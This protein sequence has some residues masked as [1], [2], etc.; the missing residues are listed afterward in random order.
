MDE[1]APFASADEFA[2]VPHALAGGP[3]GMICLNAEEIS[4]HVEG[5]AVDCDEDGRCE[6]H[7]RHG[8]CEFAGSLGLWN[9]REENRGD[10]SG[11]NQCEN[12]PDHEDDAH[13]ECQ[14]GEIERNFE[15]AECD[16]HPAFAV[17][18]CGAQL[19]PRVAVAGDSSENE[20]Q[21]KYEHGGGCEFQ[22]DARR[23][24]RKRYPFLDHIRHRR[25]VENAEAVDNT[26][27]DGDYHLRADLQQYRRAEEFPEPLAL[28]EE[29]PCLV[30]DFRVRLHKAYYTKK[31]PLRECDALPR[32]SRNSVL[33]Y[34]ALFTKIT[35]ISSQ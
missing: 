5:H 23:E 31:P 18:V 34:I 7:D 17:V 33:K 9:Y 24:F 25:N 6:C 1:D 35:I 21:E 22:D 4:V 26:V 15:S 32:R 28:P 29:P 2:A 8:G 19:E 16:L 10:S 30:S 3:V 13:S 14:P 11:R 12:H 27:H 20:G